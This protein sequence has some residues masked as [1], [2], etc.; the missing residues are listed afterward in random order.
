MKDMFVQDPDDYEVENDLVYPQD[1]LD[2]EI[3]EEEFSTSE[4]ED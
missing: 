1:S 4:E 3:L 2:I